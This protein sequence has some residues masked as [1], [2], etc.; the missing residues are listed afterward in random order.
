MARHHFIVS[1]VAM[2]GALLTCPTGSTHAATLQVSPIVI[3]FYQGTQAQPMWLTNQGDAPLRAQ[4]R[5]YKWTQ[6]GDE[7]NLELTNEV[8][9]SPPVMEIGAGQRQLLRIVRRNLAPAGREESYRVIVDELPHGDAP[10]GGDAN[11]LSFLLR[12]S[13]PAFVSPAAAPAKAFQHQAQGQMHADL[14]RIQ[15][16]NQGGA[17]IRASRLVHEDANGKTTTVMDGLIG[18]VL[19][20]GRRTWDLPA[21]A[22]SLPPGTFRIRIANDTG[23]NFLRVETPQP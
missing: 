4:V 13:I 15:I 5:I 20:H 18:Y 12:Y 16:T 7:E 8:V 11:A 1:A 10:S 21:S 2:A 3:Q 6:S 14:S 9:A 17:R 22:A 23:E 19:A